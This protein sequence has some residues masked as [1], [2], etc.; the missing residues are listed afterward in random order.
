[1]S[2]PKPESKTSRAPLRFV[3]ASDLHLERPLSGLLEIPEHLHEALRE[4][5]FQAALQVFETALAENAD[6]LLLA[7]DVIDPV[8][9]GPRAM[10]FLIA[11]FKRL[12]ARGIPVFWA[13]GR[14]DPPAAWPPSTPLPDNVHVF[15]VGRVEQRDISK[16]GEV[17]A[18]VQGISRAEGGSVDASGFHRDAHG[19]YTVGVAYLTSDSPGKEG[20]RVNYMALGGRH[21]RATVDVEPGI[22]HFPGTP[23]GRRA[24]E[25]GP[26]GCSVV[27][28]D[29]AGQ[30]TTRFVA[31][32]AV[33]WIDESVE[34]TATVTKDQLL[35]RLKERLDKLRAKNQGR[36]CLITWTIRGAGPLI[37][38]LRPGALADELLADLQKYD[39]RQQPACWSVEVCTDAEVETPAE[40]LEQETILGDA[41]RS[42]HELERNEKTPLDLTKLLP[43]GLD[44][45]ELRELATIKTADDRAAVLRGA[46]RL[47]ASLLNSDE[48]AAK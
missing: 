6:A 17:V 22:A 31:C 39:G 28:V 2:E 30:T 10:V 36:D 13:G 44:A 35:A 3:H 45:S 21:R 32:D 48:L 25:S 43:N 18:R 14:T 26:A 23:Q 19:R 4:A 38:Q 27:Q 47:A 16:R 9:A 40:W 41:M 8:K 7:G 5:P 11:Q 34:I 20:D 33:R 24:K 12:Q 1:M 15:P 37:A 42:F 29:E 46:K